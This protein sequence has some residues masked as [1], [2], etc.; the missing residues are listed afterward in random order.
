MA[1]TDQDK[2]ALESLDAAKNAESPEIQ[3]DD[4]KSVTGG[5]S[6]SGG[7]SLSSMNNAVCV[8]SD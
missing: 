5:L 2:K 6:N 7:A 4:L 1:T 3:E 8:S